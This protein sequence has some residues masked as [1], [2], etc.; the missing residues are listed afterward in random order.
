M[1]SDPVLYVDNN[2]V[3]VTRGRKNILVLMTPLLCESPRKP[4]LLCQEGSVRFTITSATGV[5]KFSE[6]IITISTTLSVRRAQT[7][8]SRCQNSIILAELRKQL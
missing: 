1:L 4:G 6:A 7:S 3:A 2:Q 8:S 5:N